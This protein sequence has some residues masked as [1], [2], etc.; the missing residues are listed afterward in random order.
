MSALALATIGGSLLSGI[1]SQSSARKQ[2]RAAAA[3]AARNRQFQERMSST[4]YQRS[5]KDLSAAG[6]NRI[7]ALGSPASSPGGAVA[8]VVGEKE[9]FAQSARQIAGDLANIANIE[10]NTAKT[11]A[12]TVTIEQ[13]RDPTIGK[14]NLGNIST[15][16]QNVAQTIKNK[17]EVV[18]LQTMREELLQT[19]LNTEQQ[20]MLMK[21]YRIHPQ[22]MLSQQFDWKGAIGSIATVIGIG[23]GVGF[24]GRALY[25]IFQKAGYKKSLAVFLKALK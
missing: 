19:Q 23:G 18:R 25:K 2:N 5:A 24:A 12:E 11:Q 8:P 14:L 16:L 10:A 1:F 15:R 7:L 20:N 17:G 13:S 9:G 22:L 4:A 3:E 21:L 6:L